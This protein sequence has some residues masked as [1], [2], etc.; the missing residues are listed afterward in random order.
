MTEWVRAGTPPLRWVVM[1]VTPD[2]PQRDAH[3]PDWAL[4]ELPVEAAGV[5]EVAIVPWPLLL[6]VRHRVGA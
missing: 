1:P 4:P 6:R 3:H 2:K 5:D